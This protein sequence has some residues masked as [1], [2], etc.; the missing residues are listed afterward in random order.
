MRVLICSDLHWDNDFDLDT[1]INNGERS[2]VATDQPHSLLRNSVFRSLIDSPAFNKLTAD[3]LI[4]IAGDVAEGS[5]GIR[6]CLIELRN[7]TAATIVSV[8]GN[9]DYAGET[10]SRL[11]V[12]R[13]EADLPDRVYLLENKMIELSGIRVLGCTLWTNPDPEVYEAGEAIMPEYSRVDDEDGQLLCV[14]DTVAAHQASVGWLNTELAKPFKGKTLVLTH[15]APSFNSQHP[16]H[17][18]SNLSAFFCVDLEKLIKQHQPELWI[19]GHLHDPV[20][21]ELENTRIVSAPLG[22]PDERG[23]NFQPVVLDV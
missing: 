2:R 12:D 6:Q 17:G 13:I 4:C 21:Y 5:E 22:Y 11:T 14:A 20:D 16:R 1:E 18:F 23:T 10:L 8:M 19:H 3:D 7:H 9:H 15:H